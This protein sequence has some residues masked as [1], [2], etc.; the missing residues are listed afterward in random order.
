L[1]IKRHRRYA[2]WNITD[3]RLGLTDTDLESTPTKKKNV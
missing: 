3:G 1:E 2:I